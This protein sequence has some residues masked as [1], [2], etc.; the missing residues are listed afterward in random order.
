MRVSLKNRGVGMRERQ[1]GKRSIEGEKIPVHFIKS[2]PRARE[3]RAEREE[4]ERNGKMV[5]I[6][7]V[8]MDPQRQV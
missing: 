3:R 2:S 7:D 6:I 1:V 8:I 4:D 5:T